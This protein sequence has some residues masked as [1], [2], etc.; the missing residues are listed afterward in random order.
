MLVKPR[1]SVPGNDNNFSSKVFE[2][3]L[4]GRAILTSRLS[5]VDAVLGNE[6]FYF[7]EHDFDRGL[8]AALK[9]VAATPRAEL[10]RRGAAIQE[11]LLTQFTWAQQGQ[12]LAGF[13]CDVLGQ[14]W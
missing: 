13:L 7:D 14:T 9:Q 10:R 3:A 8:R 5:G 1:P 6:A 2:Y 4:S 12:K 11:R